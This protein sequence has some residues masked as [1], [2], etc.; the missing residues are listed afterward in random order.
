MPWAHHHYAVC[1]PHVPLVNRSGG[2]LV[3][4]GMNRTERAAGA[5]RG[6]AAAGVLL[7][8]VVHLELWAAE[9]YRDIEVIGPSFLLNAVAGLAIGLALLTWMHWLPP[10]AAIGFGL[11]TLA[12]FVI[13][14]TVG[15]FGVHETWS[16]AP[17]ILS[18]VSEAMAVVF[19]AAAL[20]VE[21]RR[22]ARKD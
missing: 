5:L 16:G 18:A 21:A 22:P 15:L 13:S 1:P 4:Q 11:A 3:L 7:S 19:G 8:A 20:A 9:G 17:Q 6:L 12:A 10:V 14:T 2:S